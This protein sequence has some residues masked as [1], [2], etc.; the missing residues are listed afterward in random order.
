MLKYGDKIALRIN[1]FHIHGFVSWAKRY[2]NFVMMD[3]HYA[4]PNSKDALE[5]TISGKPN[6]QNVN[7]GDSVILR[8]DSGETL[9]LVNNFIQ[10]ISEWSQTGHSN[11]KKIIFTT[12][13]IQNG[14]PLLNN[15]LVWMSFSDTSWMKIG[16]H[17]DEWF[18]PLKSHSDVHMC[19]V[20]LVRTKEYKE[21]IT[22]IPNRITVEEN[23][24]YWPVPESCYFT[25]DIDAPGYAKE[26]V[27]FITDNKLPVF[28][29]YKYHCCSTRS[30]WYKCHY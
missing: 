17:K 11:I 10:L 8:L 22:H 29:F 23:E 30:Y 4:K 3:W 13:G 7:Y 27:K 2:N 24:E 18:W 20:N 26:I 25:I 21:V 1:P 28:I 15:A 9:G 16:V 12:D 19:A 6:G 14:T 5:F